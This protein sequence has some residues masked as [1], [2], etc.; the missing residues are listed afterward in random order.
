MSYFKAKMHQNWFL[1]GSVPD[2][3]R[4]A[5]STPPEPLAGFK[6]P[7]FQ[8]REGKGGE[9]RTLKRGEREGRKGVRGRKGRVLLLWEWKEGGGK[10]KGR[11]EEKGLSSPRK[12][13]LA[14]P[15]RLTSTVSC[16]VGG[17]RWLT[18][19]ILTED[20]IIVHDMSVC[21]ALMIIPTLLF[22][23]CLVLDQTSAQR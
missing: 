19:W 3:A 7:Y 5:Y 1:L 10:G 9:E 8:G 15:L 11:M 20:N 16:C 14:P 4:G 22:D 21:T 18:T 23:L 2:P 12:K 13:F 6:G 17:L